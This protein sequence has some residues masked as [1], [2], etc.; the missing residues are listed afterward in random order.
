[1]KKNITIII[2]LL[3]LAGVV[4]WAFTNYGSKMNP[5]SD[6]NKEPVVQTRE[7]SMPGQLTGNITVKVDKIDS[8]KIFYTQGGTQRSVTVTSGTKIVRQVNINGVYKDEII[9][10]ADIQ[11]GQILEL[12]NVSANG[13][14]SGIR[15]LK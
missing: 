3:V 1:M 12:D 11:A 8:G 2:G 15:I 7:P 9:S 13:D 14:V 6:T 10:S 5:G 4:Y